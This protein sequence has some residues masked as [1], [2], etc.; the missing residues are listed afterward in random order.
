MAPTFWR[1]THFECNPTCWLPVV[2]PRE[3]SIIRVSFVKKKQ[4]GR[5][6]LFWT[7][8][9]ERLDSSVSLPYLALNLLERNQ[10]RPQSG[11]TEVQDFSA[12]L[13]LCFV[14]LRP[15]FFLKGNHMGH[16]FGQGFLHFLVL[17]P[18]KVGSFHSHRFDQLLKGTTMIIHVSFLWT[19][20]QGSKKQTSPMRSVATRALDVAV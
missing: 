19:R 11:V 14:T 4:G 3:A 16:C 13:I 1:G 18:P 12:A 8:W 7:S 5:G 20:R 6:W 15:F 2:S 10:S 17:A 9:V